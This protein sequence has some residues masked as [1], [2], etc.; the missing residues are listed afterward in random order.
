LTF[1]EL[2]TNAFYPR[3]VIVSREYMAALVSNSMNATCSQTRREFNNLYTECHRYTK[4]TLSNTWVCHPDDD[5][6]IH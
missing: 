2:I 4:A 1:L 3:Q 5:L 6:A